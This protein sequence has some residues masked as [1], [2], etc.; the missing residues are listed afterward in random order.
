MPCDNILNLPEELLLAIVHRLNEEQ[1]GEW[2]FK[3]RDLKVLRATCKV[4]NRIASPYLYPV[5]YL[6][7]HQPD[8]DVFRLVANN[9]LL[10]GGVRQLIIDDTTIPASVTDWAAYKDAVAL[11]AYNKRGLYPE[12]ACGRY[13]D[14][15]DLSGLYRCFSAMTI[16]KDYWELFNSIAKGHHENRLAHADI[17]ALKEALPRLTSLH[18][19]VVSNRT[20]YDEDILVVE[21]PVTKMWRRV[22]PSIGG[23]LWEGKVPLAPRCDWGP[24]D[25]ETEEEWCKVTSLDWLDDRLFTKESPVKPDP[26]QRERSGSPESWH[27]IVDAA[28]HFHNNHR[29][30][31][32]ANR[33]GQ[34]PSILS[35]EARAIQIALLVLEDPKLSSQIRSFRVDASEDIVDDTYDPG[36]SIGLFSSLSSFAARLTRAFTTTNITSLQLILSN[37]KN[38]E[39]GR[40]VMGEGRVTQLLAS[41]PQLEHLHFEPHSM[42]T[43][44]ALPDMTYPRLRTV[45]FRCGEVDPKKLINFF[46]RHGS[47]LEYVNIRYCNILPSSEQTLGDVA[48]QLNCE[49][50][51]PLADGIMYDVIVAD[52]ILS[53]GKMG[54]VLEPMYYDRSDISSEDVEY[55]SIKK[56]VIKEADP[57]GS[58]ERK[59]RQKEH[60][61]SS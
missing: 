10:I 58:L 32:R 3:V 41:V 61:N 38:T 29:A 22:A 14:R 7:C 8:L 59:R 11:L 12:G 23:L 48:D 52:T 56:G 60:S 6:S 50:I 46:R 2:D 19:L 55:W 47:T 1:Y 53:C 30:M 34:D 42:A 17:N 35:R 20:V 44:G 27:G 40:A 39:K 51:M 45:F 43:V 25:I 5:L 21:S 33:V 31:Y 36:L 16:K 15:G 18:T 54:D 24:Y 28:N 4:F 9:P 26:A 13:E 57:Y 37:Y 49:G